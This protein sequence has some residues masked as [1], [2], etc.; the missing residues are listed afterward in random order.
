MNQQH[1]L[2]PYLKKYYSNGY[3]RSTIDVIYIL[4]E[5]LLA[6][7]LLFIPIQVAYY[8]LLRSPDVL[9]PITIRMLKCRQASISG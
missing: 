9:L 2:L 6:L 8:W 5:V 7:Y 1:P 4:N 3:I